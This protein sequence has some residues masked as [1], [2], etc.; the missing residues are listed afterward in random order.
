MRQ[1]A[2]TQEFRKNELA[3]KQIDHTLQY[4]SGTSDEPRDPWILPENIEEYGMRDRWAA[5]FVV[6]TEQILAE[7]S[8]RFP[9]WMLF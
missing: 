8:G 6:P 9:L 4:G 3:A 2:R 5:K 7:V 1:Q